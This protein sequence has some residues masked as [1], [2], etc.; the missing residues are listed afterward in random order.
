MST[1]PANLMEALVSL[2]KRRGFIYQSSEIYGDTK[3]PL[4][5][6]ACIQAH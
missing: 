2:A 3:Q 4:N 6:A 1:E 5:S